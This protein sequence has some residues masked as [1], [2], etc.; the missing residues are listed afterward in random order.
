MQNFEQD[1]QSKNPTQNQKANLT[2]PLFLL[3]HFNLRQIALQTIIIS[4]CVFSLFFI[5]DIVV[6]L[7]A[8]IAISSVLNK[9]SSYLSKIIK[10]KALSLAIIFLLFW[11]F[12]FLILLTLMPAIYKQSL[13]LINQLPSYD[14]YINHEVLPALKHKINIIDP[15]LFERIGKA[16]EKLTSHAL[17]IAVSLV[18]ELWGY[19]IATVNIIMFCIFLP[20]FTIYITKDWGLFSQKSYELKNIFNKSMLKFFH[21]SFLLL[22][23]YIKGQSQVCLLMTLYYCVGLKLIGM[24]FG[25]L[26][27]ILSGASIIIPFVGIFISFTLS[28]IIS[29][30]TCGVNYQLLYIAGLYFCG[31]IAEAYIITPKVIGSKLGLHPIVIIVSVLICGKLFG[32][33]GVLIAAPLAGILKI[34]FKSVAHKEN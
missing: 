17:D 9:L 26:L 21:E 2:C 18:Q 34:L 24:E 13:E 20:I 28:M 30:I 4:L 29:L 16:I 7:I 6:L 8:S 5:T 22:I 33:I 27:G 14:Q 12:I 23:S 11:S 31:Q 19:M 15:Q 1:I 32:L 25:L 10:S 3:Q